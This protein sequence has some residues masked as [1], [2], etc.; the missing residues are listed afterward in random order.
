MLETSGEVVP[1]KD[2]EGVIRMNGRIK[3]VFD[4]NRKHAVLL[5][6]KHQVSQLIVKQFYNEG[7][8]PDHLMVM[9][10]VRKTYWIIVV[11]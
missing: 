7:I 4:E 10:E 9:A 3:N 8:H 5:P 2:E 6:K 11:R 1:L